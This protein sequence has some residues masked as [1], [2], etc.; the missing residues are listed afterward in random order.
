MFVMIEKTRKKEAIIFYLTGKIAFF[1]KVCVFNNLLGL[2]SWSY[3]FHNNC[4]NIF[5]TLISWYLTF[6]MFE[7]TKKMAKIF[8]VLES[9]LFFI[10]LLGSKN[11]I[12]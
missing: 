8:S 3:Y 12:L 1:S 4:Q 2:K 9:L 7:N 11:L 10:N 6:V 5:R